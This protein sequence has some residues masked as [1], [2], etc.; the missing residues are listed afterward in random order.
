MSTPNKHHFLPRTYLNAFTNSQKQLFQQRKGYIKI[1]PKSPKQICYIPNY[2]KYNSPEDLLFHKLKDHHFIEKEGFKKY[3]NSYAKLLRKIITPSLYPITLKKSEILLFL[4]I[5]I[6][7]KRR[8]PTYRKFVIKSFVDMVNSD[9][10]KK[11]TQLGIEISRRINKIDP[12]KY[13]ETF[14]R[15]VTYNN[16]KQADLYL[17]GFLV[18]S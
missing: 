12:D 6:S 10:F 16:E 11:D 4:E 3:E 18:L 9:Q 14:I 5:L 13:L 7:F 8:S 17:Q 15:N 1:D 2:F